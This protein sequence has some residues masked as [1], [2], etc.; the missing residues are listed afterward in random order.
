MTLLIKQGRSY[1]RYVE[2]VLAK[3]ISLEEYGS[4]AYLG[5]S[6]NSLARRTRELIEALPS[7]SLTELEE[8]SSLDSV[9][10]A[11]L[12]HD[13]SRQVEI[14]AELATENAE[15]A[16][17]VKEL[18]GALGG[19]VSICERNIYPNPDVDPEHLLSV[20]KRAQAIIAKKEG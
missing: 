6:V 15:L 1:S 4:E 10:N 18:E 8:P 12:R 11:D 17:R 14:A 20:M 9:E 16:A 19:L 2:D 5:E 7:G 3:L 13:L